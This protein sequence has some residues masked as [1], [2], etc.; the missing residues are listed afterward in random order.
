MTSATSTEITIDGNMLSFECPH[1]GLWTLVKQNEINCAIF[2][3]G[4]YKDSK[5]QL[6]PHS[7]KA[8]CDAAVG[9]IYG[10]GKPFKIVGNR[11]E[12]C[13]YI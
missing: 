10:C 6:P 11:V 1:C 9:S 12:K 4:I 8:S 2:R 3:H 7:S 13:D 5:K